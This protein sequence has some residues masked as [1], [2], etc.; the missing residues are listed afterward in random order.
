MS[1]R[2]EQAFSRLRRG[3]WNDNPLG[4]PQEWPFNSGQVESQGWL[5]DGSV[6]ADVIEANAVVAGKIDADAVTAREIA[7]AT[8]TASEI[9]AS[10][11]TGSNI[12]ADTITGANIAANTITAS[13]IAADSITTSELAANAVITEN[14]LA[15]NV[16]SS[17]I[18]LTISGKNLGANSG[19]SGNPGIYFDANSAVGLY[20]SSPVVGLVTNQASGNPIQTWNSTGTTFVPTVIPDAGGSRNLGSTT[21]RWANIY[22]VNTPNVSSDRRLKRDIED[23]P[24]GLDFVRSL[25]PRSFRYRDCE[26]TQAREAAAAGFD[27]QALRRELEP[28]HDS[29][30]AIR[31]KQRTGR[32]SDEEGNQRVE[33]LRAKAADIERRYTAPVHEAHAKRRTGRRVHYGLIAQEVKES[34]DAAG[35]DAAFWTEDPEGNQALAHTELLA[36]VIRAIQEVADEN[37]QLRSR[38]AALE[39]AAQHAE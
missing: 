11:I 2:V 8:I 34:L 6:T 10:T 36:P 14:I 7:A 1:D 35:V 4:V 24:L 30:S 23:S 26:D 16:T 18:E 38:V 9:A 12:A 33:A 31:A 27:E 3:P 21:A 28:I 5:A 39:Q 37:A 25:R 15:A 13:E 22:L 20:F 17:R 29:I 32:L 19:S